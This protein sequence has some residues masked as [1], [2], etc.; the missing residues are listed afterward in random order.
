MGGS[1]IVVFESSD[2]SRVLD[3]YA[4]D[5]SQ[6]LEDNCHNW[7]LGAYEQNSTHTFVEVSR[8]LD[9]NDLQDRPFVEGKM[10]VIVAFGDSESLSYHESKQ[11][12]TVE[13][14]PSSKSSGPLKQDPSTKLFTIQHSID[15]PSTTTGYMCNAVELPNDKPYHIIQVKFNVPDDVKDYIHH[16]VVHHC[17]YDDNPRNYIKNYLN[18]SK[19][20]T[21]A[22]GRSDVGCYGMVF[23]YISGNTFFTMPEGVGLRIGP[24]EYDIKYLVFEIHYNN[25]YKTSGLVD[26]TSVDIYYTEQLRQYDAGIMFLGDTFGAEMPIPPM[27]ESYHVESECP[28]YCT[29]KWPHPIH[30][31]TDLLHMHRH[32]DMAY[33]TV[34]RNGTSIQQLNRVEYFDIK[35]QS[36]T[37]MDVIINPGDSINT[38]CIFSN[39]G[40][41]PVP[42]SIQTDA[43]MCMEFISYY[44]KLYTK[45]GYTT[46]SK[47]RASHIKSMNKTATKIGP[48]DMVTVC[49][50]LEN[51]Y[52]S[53]WKKNQYRINPEVSTFDPRDT[54]KQFGFTNKASLYCS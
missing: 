19:T 5:E 54:K 40:K 22:V 12:G 45:G 21:T 34:N 29:S 42:F 53:D 43:E 24:G 28:S 14:I 30:I 1:D 50:S 51:A 20:C 9:T 27:V 39:S 32:G 4:V 31:I 33:S 47:Y 16:V 46:C 23:G 25:D 48:N 7:K 6:P 18:K 41:K 8:K 38:H 11:V 52:D 44:P 26:E 37:D 49:G 10:K 15:I 17:E 3:L 2:P 36:R 13:F 35:Y